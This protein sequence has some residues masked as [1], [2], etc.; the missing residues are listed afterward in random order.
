MG[1]LKTS[2]GLAAALLLISAASSASAQ[3]S[4]TWVSGIGWRLTNP[5]SRTAPCK[6]LAGALSKT[7]IGGEIS[8]L[9]PAGYGPVTITKSVTINGTPGAGYGSIAHSCRASPA[10]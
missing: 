1:Q 4:R 2:C 8:V 7:A 3:A 10:S 9:D 5:C 6:T